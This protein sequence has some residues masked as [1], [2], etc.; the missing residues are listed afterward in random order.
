[1]KRREF[2]TMLGGAAAAWPLVARAQM[3]TVPVR[4]IGRSRSCAAMCIPPPSVTTGRASLELA[5]IAFSDIDMV[6]TW[7]PE[8]AVIRA[9]ESG[10]VIAR[11]ESRITLLDSE[12]IEDDVRG[13]VAEVSQG[14]NGALHVKMHDKVAAL[15]KLARVLGMYRVKVDVS[16]TR[17]ATVEFVYCGARDR[18]PASNKIHDSSPPEAAV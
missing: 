9:L 3:P 5:K 12:E 18:M 17:A 2:V 7:G 10:A 14:A 11:M 15:D 13:A 8:A 1:M 6:V 4:R 16:H